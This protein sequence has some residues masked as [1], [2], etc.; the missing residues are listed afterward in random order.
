[1]SLSQPQK[2][3]YRTPLP[4]QVPTMPPRNPSLTMQ[5]AAR[6]ESIRIAILEA[7]KV[8]GWTAAEHRALENMR[9]AVDF[10]YRGS[11]QQSAS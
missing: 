10:I 8:H 9:Q 7:F 11:A 3:K 5:Q 1:M 4:G 2:M 6:L